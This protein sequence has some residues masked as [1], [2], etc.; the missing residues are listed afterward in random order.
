MFCTLIAPSFTCWASHMT[1]IVTHSRRWSEQNQIRTGLSR[2]G[3]LCLVTDSCPKVRGKITRKIKY[4]LGYDPGCPY[5]NKSVFQLCACS[6]ISGTQ[7]FFDGRG[8]LV[9]RAE[10]TLCQ[11]GLHTSCACM[12]RCLPNIL[13]CHARRHRPLARTLRRVTEQNIRTMICM[14]QTYIRAGVTVVWSAKHFWSIT[15]FCFDS[16]FRRVVLNRLGWHPDWV[17]VSVTVSEMFWRGDRCCSN[18]ITWP[19]KFPLFA[20]STCVQIFQSVACLFVISFIASKLREVPPIPWP[21]EVVFLSLHGIDG[22]AGS[23]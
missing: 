5:L 11:R 8:S 3:T 2:S 10:E 20:A 13:C 7:S 19:Q 16:I 21:Q 9:S 12:C 17:Q 23:G 4:Q 1:C 22:K 6:A 14:C 15:S 18:T